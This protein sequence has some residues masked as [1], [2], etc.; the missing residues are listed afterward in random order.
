MQ[1]NSIV[2][3]SPSCS[4]SSESLLKDLIYIPNK[5]NT[6]IPCLFLDH[7]CSGE[8]DDIT[9]GM[10]KKGKILVYFHGNAEDLGNTFMQMN[11]LR[12][13]LGVRII[14]VEYR[15]YGLYGGV[16]KCSEGFLED[17]L[18]VYDFVSKEMKVPQSDI[19]LFGRSLGCTAVSFIASQRQPEIV[20]LMSPFKSL[21]EAAKAI[22]GN[23]LGSML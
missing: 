7:I 15:G 12:E 2:F 20:I 6:H 16:S 19:L 9:R 3:A 11:A 23:F 17:A 10:M 8:L 1:L 4:Y 21:Q 5:D 13:T 14:A 22:V 18:T